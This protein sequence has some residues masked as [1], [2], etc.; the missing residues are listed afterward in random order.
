[1]GTRTNVM[2]TMNMRPGLELL[3]RAPTLHQIADSWGKIELKLETD[4]TRYWITTEGLPEKSTVAPINFVI[5]YVTV[6][7][8]SAQGNWDLSAV[9]SPDAWKLSQGFDYCQMLY[10][11]LREL[12]VRLEKNFSWQLKK[13]IEE[14][15]AE[16]QRTN[17][18]V[19]ALSEKVAAATQ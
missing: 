11:E 5:G 13:E 15:W 4:D 3:R 18:A 2:S 7:K 9:Y 1:M 16:L 17:R 14:L 10:R 12:N 8:R 19:L 6:E